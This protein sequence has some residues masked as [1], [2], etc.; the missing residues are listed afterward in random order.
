MAAVEKGQVII[1]ATSG[2]A[3]TGF[4]RVQALR[5]TGAIAAIQNTDGDAICAFAAEGGVEFPCGLSVNG[6]KRGAGAGTLYVYL[7]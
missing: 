3:V 4:R 7:W 6:I 1:M 2:D 5:A